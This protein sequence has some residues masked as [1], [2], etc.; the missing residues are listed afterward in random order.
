MVLAVPMTAPESYWTLPRAI[1]APPARLI[2]WLR[3]AFAGVIAILTY[4]AR[5]AGVLFVAAWFPCVIESACRLV[6]EWLLFSSP[7]K[8]PQWLAAEDFDPPTWLTAFVVTPWAAMAWAF[9]LG[10]MADRSSKRGM[11]QTLRVPFRW[12]RFELSPAILLAA[13]IF[14]A[15]NLFDAALRFGERSILLPLLLRD[16]DLSEIG[17]DLWGSSIVAGHIALM[18]VVMAWSYPVAGHVLG[19]GKFDVRGAWW[20]LRG[21]LG[22]YTAFFFFMTVALAALDR[23]IAVPKGSLVRLVAPSTPWNFLEATIRYV[24]DFPL[25]MLMIVAWAVAVGIML[26]AQTRQAPAVRRKPA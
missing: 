19:T 20:L 14:S 23:I 25:S 22:R 7:P 2:L 18:A 5:H 21:N 24:L 12:V 9:V 17:F 8:M 11:I 4:C 6:L 13:T 10:T 16:T 15:T 1:P 26:E 3:D